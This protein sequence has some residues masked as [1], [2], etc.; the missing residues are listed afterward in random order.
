MLCWLAQLASYCLRYSC[1]SV[2]A[3]LNWEARMALPSAK[4]GANFESRIRRTHRLGLAL[5]FISS[6]PGTNGVSK[7]LAALGARHHG[8][9][10]V[11]F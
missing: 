6:L 3:G 8:E 10:V 9:L 4:S 1:C 11:L 7:G 5:L 2:I